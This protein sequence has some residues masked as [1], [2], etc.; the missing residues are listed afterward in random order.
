MPYAE[1]N[2]IRMDVEEYAGRASSGLVLKAWCMPG[3]RASAE[4]L[5]TSTGHEDPSAFDSAV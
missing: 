4:R 2:D 5:G 3:A 1:V